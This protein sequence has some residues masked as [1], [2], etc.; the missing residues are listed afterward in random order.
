MSADR[1]NAPDYPSQSW[2]RTDI[3]WRT[4]SVRQ[5]W[6][7][8]LLFSFPLL[9]LVTSFGIGLSSF[10]FLASALYYLRDSH[11]TL[12]RHWPQ[13]RWVV[14]AFLAHLGFALFCWATRGAGLHILEAPARMLF[15]MSAMLVVQ[16]GRPWRGTLWWGVAGGALAAACFAAWQRWLLDMPRP[17]GMMN[18]ITF[19]DLSLCLALLALA[20]ALDVRSLRTPLAAPIGVLAGIAGSLLSG[21]RG[22][23]IVLPFAVALFMRQRRFISRR[24]AVALPVLACLLFTLAYVVPQTGVSERMAIGIRDV[25]GYLNGNTSATS[26]SVRLELWKAAAMLIYEHPVTGLDTAAYKQQMHDWVARGLLDQAVFAP[27]E[28]SHLHNDVLQVLVTKGVPGFLAWAGT[29]LAPL[30]FFSARLKQS[31]RA[32][33][34]NAAA[35]AGVLV[36]LAYFGF[37]L[38]EVIFWSLKACLFY[39]LLVFIL[40]GSCL[41]AQEDAA[42][43]ASPS[44]AAPARRGSCRASR[45]SHR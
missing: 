40:M 30:L 42:L 3:N 21:S 36:V 17:G 8:G 45:S 9:S 27:P 24:T 19:G 29:L 33:E 1:L 5:V 14:Y 26:L 38:T 41:N 4:L 12:L 15:A 44:Q 37:G 43:A 2:M 25:A 16:I 28:P 10:L 39:A 34:C 32:G 13:T 35:L 22:G 6:L 11:S 23:W 7:A 20:S 31:R 18:P